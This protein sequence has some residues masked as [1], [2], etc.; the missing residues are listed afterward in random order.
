MRL[1]QCSVRCL[2]LGK[3]FG[4]LW[5]DVSAVT[6]VVWR[7]RKEVLLRACVSMAKGFVYISVLRCEVILWNLSGI[8]VKSVISQLH[9]KTF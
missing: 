3:T 9:L 4:M 1:K 6:A 8:T 7:E 5:T 2:Y